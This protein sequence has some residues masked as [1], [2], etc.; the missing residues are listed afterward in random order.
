[1]PVTFDLTKN[2]I[3]LTHSSQDYDRRPDIPLL[4]Q[5][6]FLPSKVWNDIYIELNLYKMY[7][8]IIHPQS[9]HLIKMH[10]LEIIPVR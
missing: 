8:M 6:F 5:L 3:S 9:R 4:R 7:E 1:M 10:F 2:S